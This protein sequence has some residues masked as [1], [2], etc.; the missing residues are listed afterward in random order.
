MVVYLLTSLPT[1]I[2]VHLMSKN[3]AKFFL[4]VGV[5]GWAEDIGEVWTMESGVVWDGGCGLGIS[6]YG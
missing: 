5:L 2:L 4:G 1:S 6:V 3:T